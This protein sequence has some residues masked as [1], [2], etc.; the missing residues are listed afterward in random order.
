MGRSRGETMLARPSG[1]RVG[2]L[3]LNP[4]RSPVLHVSLWRSEITNINLLFRP[5][6]FSSTARCQRKDHQSC[7][8]SACSCSR[9][10]F[11]PSEDTGALFVQQTHVNGPNIP[12]PRNGD[13]SGYHPGAPT[14]LQLSQQPFQ[15]IIPRRI[16]PQAQRPGFECV[17]LFILTMSIG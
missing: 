6:E 4:L 3:M 16:F 5:A 15:Q 10:R 8:S 13:R 12:T 11:T 17:K 14:H 9:E 2:R 1:R 7:F